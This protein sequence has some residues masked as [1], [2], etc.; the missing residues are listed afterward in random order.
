M[1]ADGS[2]RTA[3]GT[4]LEVGTCTERLFAITLLSFDAGPLSQA[5]PK[6]TPDNPDRHKVR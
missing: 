6:V 2:P 5:L 4:F 3:R 1:W